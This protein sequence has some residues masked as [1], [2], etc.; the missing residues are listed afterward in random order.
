M[1]SQTHSL[2]PFI[3]SSVTCHQLFS[4]GYLQSKGRAGEGPN[5]ILHRIWFCCDGEG[6]YTPMAGLRMKIF[7]FSDRLGLP[8]WLRWYRIHLL[9][10]R[11]RFDAWVGKIPWRREW[12]PTPV[13]LPGEFHGQRSLAGY[14]P[15][16]HKELDTTERLTQ[17]RV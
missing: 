3:F 13:I 12:Q 1:C 16:G 17:H 7:H 11:P 6:Q 8:W 2:Y 15:W 5:Y 9:C 10:R 4:T 14:S